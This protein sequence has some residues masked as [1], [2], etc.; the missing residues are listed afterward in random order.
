MQQE[1]NSMV[2]LVACSFCGR[3]VDIV[4]HLIANKRPATAYICWDCVNLCTEVIQENCWYR[5]I[6]NLWLEEGEDK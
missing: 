2:M 6:R 5:D 4:Q 3:D 1:P